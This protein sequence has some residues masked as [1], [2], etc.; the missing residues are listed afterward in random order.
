MERRTL[1]TVFPA[2][3][4]KTNGI[5]SWILDKLGFARAVDVQPEEFNLDSFTSPWHLLKFGENDLVIISRR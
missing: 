3:V 4:S 5:W 1:E 2:S